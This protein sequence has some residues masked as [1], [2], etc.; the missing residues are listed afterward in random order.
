MKSDASSFVQHHIDVLPLANSIARCGEGPSQTKRKPAVVAFYF[1]TFLI[2]RPSSLASTP[3][4]A[5]GRTIGQKLV[6][7][8]SEMGL[9]VVPKKLVECYREPQPYLLPMTLRS[10]VDII[11]KVEDNSY[12]AMDMRILANAILHRYMSVM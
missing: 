9:D 3:D 5:I 10:L 1:W 12:F 11:R 4:S 8:R 2:D 6:E 7:N